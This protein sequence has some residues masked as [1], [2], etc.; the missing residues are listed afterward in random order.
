[1]RQLATYELSQTDAELWPV[2]YRRAR[3]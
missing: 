1:M 3:P 2:Q